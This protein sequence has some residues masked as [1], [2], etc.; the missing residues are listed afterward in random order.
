MNWCFA[1]RVQDLVLIVLPG[2]ISSRQWLSINRTHWWSAMRLKRSRFL[3]RWV[4]SRHCRLDLRTSQETRCFGI[5]PRSE[6][7]WN[8]FG[9]WNTCRI[10]RSVFAKSSLES[11][12][13]LF[14]QYQKGYIIRRVFEKRHIIQKEFRSAGVIRR[15]S[16]DCIRVS[17]PHEATLDKDSCRCRAVYEAKSQLATHLIL[18]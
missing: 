9:G 2:Q 6:R 12:S 10:W 3:R 5:S 16:W 18:R 14:S 1:W 7:W 17:C 8:D 4:S 13:D 11:I 15:D